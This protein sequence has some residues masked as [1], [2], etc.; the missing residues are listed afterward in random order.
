M[1]T[2]VRV[3]DYGTLPRTSPLLV[4][5]PGAGDRPRRLHR[6]A[7][8]AF[9]NLA[10]A[11]RDD[12]GLEL[13]AASGWRPHR[14]QSYEQY[15]QVVLK[16]FG[17]LATGRRILAFAS[18]H[19]TG[20][21]V[22]LEAGGLG[23]SFSDRDQQRE[24]PLHRWLVEHAHEHGWT[25]YAPEPWHWEYPICRRAWETG[26]F[27]DTGAYEHDE[28]EQLVERIDDDANE[29]DDEAL[30]A[31]PALA[32]PSPDSAAQQPTAQR[33]ATSTR[34]RDRVGAA[35]AYNDG[36]DYSSAQIRL[37]QRVVGVDD[38]GAWNRTTVEA[39]QQWQRQ[40]E[41]KVDGKVGPK[42]LVAFFQAAPDDHE[43]PAIVNVGA[44]TG[45]S[46]LRESSRDVDFCVAHG[47]N[48]LDVIVN[49]H[50]NKR[51]LTPF[52]TYR[53][54][55]ILELCKKARDAGIEVH[56]MSW[57]MPHAP[58]IEQAADSLIGLC[59]ETEA[60]SLQWD[61]EEPWTQAVDAQP[62]ED[63]A[64]QIAEAFSSAPCPMGV[65]GIG[66]TPAK[67]FGPLARVCEYLVPQCYATAGSRATPETVVSLS[68]DRWR[69]HFG[70]DRRME[71]GLAAYRQDGVQ[72][73][74]PQSAMTASLANVRAYGFDTVIYWNLRG[75]QTSPEIAS[76][77]ANIRSTDKG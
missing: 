54:P 61:A 63:A 59:T 31:A 51:G 15:K 75:I 36:R 40:H 42:T 34:R 25:P 66:F 33:R 13:R 55:K 77:V 9:T 56:L 21:V 44:W 28:D 38:D 76:V 53:R 6:L 49:D 20:L 43:Q 10:Q 52:D 35:I 19:E 73:H 1:S 24:T 60:T 4:D 45:R 18:S 48:R 37:V 72:G 46:S 71:I 29:I 62:Y 65:N 8:E 30:T 26:Q 27:D 2:R 3:K 57:I 67:K 69:R 5:I 58:Y 14:W 16:R 22:D 70:K 23:P 50:S 74:T 68:V 12:L 41:L 7:A 47:I 17:S 64:A 11:V 39:V 32:D